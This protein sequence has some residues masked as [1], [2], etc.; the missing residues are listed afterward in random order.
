AVAAFEQ[1]DH[2][3]EGPYATEVVVKYPNTVSG[4]C[5]SLVV[6]QKSGS[7]RDRLK[8]VVIYNEERDDGGD[9]FADI[10]NVEGGGE[11]LK[12][13]FENGQCKA[14][15]QCYTN[16]FPDSVEIVLSCLDDGS[17]KRAR[18]TFEVAI[19]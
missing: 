13:V 4:N 1:A 6:Y 16:G 8:E 7:A 15:L 10:Y 17:L 2:Q 12:A 11:K 9:K 5:F 3:G 18:D 14:K 19:V